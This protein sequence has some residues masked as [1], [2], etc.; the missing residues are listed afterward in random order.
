MA[1]FLPNGEVLERFCLRWKQDMDAFCLHLYSAIASA[2]R[3]ERVQ[4]N[5]RIKVWKG[6]AKLSL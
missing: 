3:K 1:N 2:V 5:Q 6:K 4:K